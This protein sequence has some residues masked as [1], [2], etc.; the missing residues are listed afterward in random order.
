MV[1]V[2]QQAAE[3]RRVESNWSREDFVESEFSRRRMIELNNIQHRF[4]L[5]LEQSSWNGM[6]SNRVLAKGREICGAGSAALQKRQVFLVAPVSSLV[7][8]TDLWG[9]YQL[10]VTSL[11]RPSWC[12]KCFLLLC[13]STS[14]LNMIILNKKIPVFTCWIVGLWVTFYL[15]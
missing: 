7:T 15:N 8:M 2:F 10:C 13:F 1:Q 3:L 14:K 4:F 12:R 6:E 9:G 11:D 5:M